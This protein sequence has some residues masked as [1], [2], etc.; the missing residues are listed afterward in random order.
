MIVPQGID[1]VAEPTDINLLFEAQKK[2]E[3]K[4]VGLYI[5]AQYT[6]LP[7]LSDI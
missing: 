5:H 4:K 1:L 3:K 2:K 6:P 7:L